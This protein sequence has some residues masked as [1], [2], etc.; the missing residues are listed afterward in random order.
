MHENTV[1][2]NKIATK[3]ILLPLNS[4]PN[5]QLE[6]KFELENTKTNIK[7]FWMLH[8]KNKGVRIMSKKSVY[9]QY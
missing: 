8:T 3:T 1:Y 7:K 4:F 9:Y 2:E 6:Q 5:L